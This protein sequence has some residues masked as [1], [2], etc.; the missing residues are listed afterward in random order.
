M[1]SDFHEIFEDKF[2]IVQSNIPSQIAP[3]ELGLQIPSDEIASGSEFIKQIQ[4]L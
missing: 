4:F 3:L 1:L 2:K